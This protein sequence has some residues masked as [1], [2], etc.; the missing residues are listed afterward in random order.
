[1]ENLNKVIKTMNPITDGAE[2]FLSKLFGAALSEAGE[3]LADQIKYYR[4]KNQAKIFLKAKELLEK[5]GITP[6]QINI[7][8]LFPLMEYTSFE[9]EEDVQDIWSNVIA[10]ISSYE[11]EQIFNLKCL[12][13]LKE[14]TP[15]EIKLLD[16]LFLKFQEDEKVTL[17]R[18]KT[19]DWFKER[20]SVYPDNTIFSPWE[21]KE[22]LNLT[23]NQIDMYIDRLISFGIIKYE[24]PSL[25]KFE[26]KS[27]LPDYYTGMNLPIAEKAYE[28]E[29]S[30]RVHF[31]NFG[32]YFVKLCKY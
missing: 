5:K 25:S 9:E 8:L 17:E 29:T 27:S 18:W 26:Q 28:L 16:L 13:I 6:N 21:F 2:K 7:K 24:Q 30:E 31:T 19:I 20:D 1:M 10:N 32:L 3:M 12:G 22:S 15:N 14:I 23:E 11:T 4:L